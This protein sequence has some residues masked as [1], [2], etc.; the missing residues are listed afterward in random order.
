M[1]NFSN[2]IEIFKPQIHYYF[3]SGP[4]DVIGDVVLVSVNDINR[5]TDEVNR[6]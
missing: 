2:I 1:H 5:T 3:T 6:C 4:V